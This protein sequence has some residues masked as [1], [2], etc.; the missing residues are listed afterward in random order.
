MPNPKNVR[1]VSGAGIQTS[2]LF[3]SGL[4]PSPLDQGSHPIKV[5]IFTIEWIGIKWNKKKVRK[6]E[7]ERNRV[8][9]V[10]RKRKWKQ[11]ESSVT[12]KELQNVY[13]S[14]PN[15]ISL[16]KWYILTH[17]QKLP[18][19][20]AELGKLIVAKGFEKLPK[21]QQIAQSGHTG[22]KWFCGT[23]GVETG[24]ICICLFEKGLIWD[25]RKD[26]FRTRDSYNCFHLIS[27]PSRIAKWQ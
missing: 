18:K 2:N 13:K 20:V 25:P 9:F 7:R 19:N 24:S 10:V 22:W 8:K 26:K 1:P 6:R 14:C 23:G 27:H 16:E 11:G 3:N 5:R 21:V 17:L 15:M 4:L 12:R